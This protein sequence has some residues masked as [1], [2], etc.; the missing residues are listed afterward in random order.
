MKVN[1]LSNMIGGWFAGD[2]EPVLHKTTDYEVAVKEYKAGDY[3]KAHLHKLAKEFT[4]ILHGKVK[5]NNV[6]YH[7]G[8]IIE[9]ETHEPTDFLAITDVTTVVLKTKSAKNDKYIV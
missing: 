2:F 5:M 9:I 8:D 3:E 7:H 6:E 1:K 4:V